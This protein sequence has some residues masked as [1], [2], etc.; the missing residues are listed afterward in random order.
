MAMLGEKRY[1]ALKKAWE[2][3]GHSIQWSD[4]FDA[5]MRSDE[6]YV[7]LAW[8]TQGYIEC[9]DLYCAGGLWDFAND[10]SEPLTQEQWKLLSIIPECDAYTYP[11]DEQMVTI[12]HNERLL[13][14]TKYAAAFEIYREGYD[15]AYGSDNVIDKWVASTAFSKIKKKR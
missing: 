11:D 7:V 5:K 9:A 12:E 14:D 6:C 1:A 8:K 10:G 15:T 3:Y 13:K 4:L 2:D